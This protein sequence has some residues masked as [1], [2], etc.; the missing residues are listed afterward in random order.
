MTQIHHYF[1]IKL[2]DIR[3]YL[4]VW[5]LQIALSAA[6]TSV[7]RLP[8][9]NP[10]ENYTEEVWL[11]YKERIPDEPFLTLYDPDRSEVQI[12]SSQVQ[13]STKVFDSGAY[14]QAT[15]AQDLDV[16]PKLR[17]WMHIATRFKTDG[18]AVKCA[19][20]VNG[21][22]YSCVADLVRSKFK[23]LS[24]RFM[25]V[26]NIGAA[27][28]SEIHVQQLRMVEPRLLQELQTVERCLERVR[29]QLCDAEVRFS[30][31]ESMIVR[32]QHCWTDTGH[33]ASTASQTATRFSK[34]LSPTAAT[35][36][37]TPTASPSPAQISF[38]SAKT[39]TPVWPWPET[40]PITVLWRTSC[41][42]ATLPA[43]LV[44]SSQ[45]P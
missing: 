15:I 13:L 1:R 22:Q 27:L 17:R 6:S 29:D 7:L 4:L 35:G 12:S 14:I 23:V 11:Y 36:F 37:L 9:P 3:L 42:S 16:L 44:P 20:L 8:L 38:V 45:S 40:A 21:M 26:D 5:T 19:V 18:T 2:M 43:S 28:S 24:A 41:W 33:C 31:V 25:P 32:Q 10:T 34:T 39:S 30:H